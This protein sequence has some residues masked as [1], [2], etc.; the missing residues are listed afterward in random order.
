VTTE[1]RGHWPG[2]SIA[3]IAQHLE[4]IHISGRKKMTKHM[5]ISHTKFIIINKDHIYP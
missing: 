2:Q 1:A 4:A 5:T 3:I